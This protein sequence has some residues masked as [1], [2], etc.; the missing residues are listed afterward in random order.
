M[1]VFNPG[2]S[3]T[4]PLRSEYDFDLNNDC[5]NLRS[6]LIP[7]T[8]LTGSGDREIDLSKIGVFRWLLCFLDLRFSHDLLLLS[9]DQGLDFF[10]YIF[11]LMKPEFYSGITEIDNGVTRTNKYCS[12]ILIICLSS[13]INLIFVVLTGENIAFFPWQR[14]Q[15]VSTQEFKARVLKT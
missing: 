4:T 9:V 1:K 2:I 3:I 6:N 11:Y 12:C 10:W 8:F 7:S 15:D 13:D 14:C 5:S